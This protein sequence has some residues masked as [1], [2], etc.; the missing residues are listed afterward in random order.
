M[1]V[2]K[3]S[4][5]L[6]VRRAPLTAFSFFERCGNETGMR[7]RTYSA[8]S[9]G[10]DGTLVEV[11]AALQSSLP[12]IIITG[13]PGE[14]VKESRERVRAS[15]ASLG[16]QIPNGRVLIHLSPATAKKHGSQFD[17]SI[18][19]AVLQAENI[20]GAANLSR[21]AFFGELSLDGRL[22][23]IRGILPM[24]EV[25]ST[26]P[27][28]DWIIIP[29][30]NAS[31]VAWLKSNKVKKAFHVSEVID[32]VRGAINLE[33][34]PFPSLKNEQEEETKQF[35]SILGQTMAKRALAIALA[36]RH[37][38]LMVGPAGVGKSMLASSTPELLPPLKHGEVLELKK[39]Y[40]N[41]DKHFD[42]T[43]RPF[44]SPHHGISANALLGGGN[45]S[46]NPGE[47]SLSH[48]GVLFLDEL[49]EY[50]RDAI[51]GLRE[52]LENGVIHIHRVGASKTLPSNFTL[53]AAMNPCPC[54]N[55]T[56][57]YNHCI[58]PPEKAAKYKRRV[59]GPIMDRMGLYVLLS[60]SQDRNK[61]PSLLSGKELK[62]QVLRALEKQQERYSS[63]LMRNGNQLRTED[64]PDFELRNEAKAAFEEVLDKNVVSYR[65]MAQLKKVARTIADMEGKTWIEENHIWEAWGFRIPDTSTL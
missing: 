62:G 24:V 53:I 38:L 64:Y 16:Y 21:M 59:S 36:G 63:P 35:D 51:E 45:A 13:L 7:I 46:V 18:A 49:P 22:K 58:C 3:G 41:L 29:E 57:K 42:K 32:F 26:N 39:I 5:Y 11:E 48:Q 28:I 2:L 8:T 65:R 44:R 23:P 60:R 61:S 54:G 27:E 4:K 20:L 6:L 9:D 1:T 25:C 52:P 43:R 47:V 50:K 19:L 37:H 34:V 12:Q 14:V 40:G 17:L 10:L 55:A 30:E 15:L 56:D 33:G 31:D